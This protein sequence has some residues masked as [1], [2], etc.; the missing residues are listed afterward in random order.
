[1]GTKLTRSHLPALNKTA[2]GLNKP[3]IYTKRSEIVEEF[4]VE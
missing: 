4:K 3:A 2:T 1:M